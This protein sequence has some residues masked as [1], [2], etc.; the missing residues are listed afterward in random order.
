[1]KKTE[2]R[3]RFRVAALA[4]GIGAARFLEGLVRVRD[5][6]KLTIIVNTADDIELFGLHVSPDVDI[7]TYT[8]AGLVDKKTGWGFRRDTFFCLDQLK[9]LKQPDWF[10]LKKVS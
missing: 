3:K 4:G 6:E 7:V 8:L 10:K 2:P 9:K 5:P 1:M